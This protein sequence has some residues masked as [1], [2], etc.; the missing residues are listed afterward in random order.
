MKNAPRCLQ[1]VMEQALRKVDADQVKIY[2]GQ[3]LVHT[4]SYAEHL[5]VL[6]DVFCAFRTYNLK[7]DLEESKFLTNELIYLG[8][9]FVLNI[10]FVDLQCRSQIV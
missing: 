2:L 10:R 4:S 8:K 6:R 1:F 3:V 9:P 5:T 7:V